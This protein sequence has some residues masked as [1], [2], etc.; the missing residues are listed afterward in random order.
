MGERWMFSKLK[1]Y[2][3]LPDILCRILGDLE[4]VNSN[5]HL[6][7]SG[8]VSWTARKLGSELIFPLISIGVRCTVVPAIHDEEFSR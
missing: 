7:A 8:V 3:K 4:L 5:L 2:V 6:L 1:T